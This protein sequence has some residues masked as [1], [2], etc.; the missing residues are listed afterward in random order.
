MDQELSAQFHINKEIILDITL[1]LLFKC[2]LKETFSR[3]V[4][5]LSE[6]KQFQI[7]TRHSAEAFNTLKY[8]NEI[9]YITNVLYNEGTIMVF[10]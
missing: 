9:T 6:A 8:L 7:C 4:A 1:P 10:I 5:E 3:R 2:Q